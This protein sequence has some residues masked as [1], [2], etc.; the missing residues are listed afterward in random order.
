M[1]EATE[2]E[3]EGD[4]VE[5]ELPEH[6]RQLQAR[7]TPVSLDLWRR[8]EPSSWAPEDIQLSLQVP[9]KLFAPA[10]SSLDLWRRT[11]ASSWAPED[12]QLSLQVSKS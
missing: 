10:S 11:E 8:T 9:W 12:I 1:Q 6:L 2:E 7:Q 3:D 5:K 4:V